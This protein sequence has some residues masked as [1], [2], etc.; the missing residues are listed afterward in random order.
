MARTKGVTNIPL[1]EPKPSKVNFNK[2][3]NGRIGAGRITISINKLKA[4][5]IDEENPMI[6]SYIQDG[7]LIIE[8]EGV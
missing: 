3:G 5:G 8:K 1:E 6:V 7:K 2:D 4:I